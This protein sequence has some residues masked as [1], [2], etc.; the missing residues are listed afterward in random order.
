MIG[1]KYPS[2]SPL[3]GLEE[4]LRV[5]TEGPEDEQRNEPHAAGCP[6]D[7]ALAGSGATELQE[8]LNDLRACVRLAEIDVAECR[9]L[10]GQQGEQIARQVERAEKA[11]AELADAQK[12]SDAIMDAGFDNAAELVKTQ[13]ER[14]QLRAQVVALTQRAERAEAALKDFVE[15]QDARATLLAGI[16]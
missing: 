2:Q 8:E 6:V 14:T 4:T 3:T 9:K 13:V 7:N 11:E 15:T 12:T 1:K 10:M 5:C 16:P